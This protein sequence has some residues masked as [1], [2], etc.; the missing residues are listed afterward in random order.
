[1]VISLG[2]VILKNQSL[3]SIVYSDLDPAVL[4]N[5]LTICFIDAPDVLKS[6]SDLPIR[7]NMLCLVSLFFSLR[8]SPIGVSL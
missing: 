2:W 4:K 3:N 6:S 5:T 1:M 7:V 8:F